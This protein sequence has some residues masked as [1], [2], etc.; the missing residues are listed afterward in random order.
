MESW[1][2]IDYGSKMRGT[3]AVAC[4]KDGMLQTALSVKG[5]DADRWLL[6]L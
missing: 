5:K 1:L 2:G 4:E 3:T 6:I